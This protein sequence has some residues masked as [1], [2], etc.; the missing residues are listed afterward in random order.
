L[1]QNKNSIVSKSQ[2]L[3]IWLNNSKY[4]SEYLYGSYSRTKKSVKSAGDCPR[5]MQNA[6]V[7]G[8]CERKKV[9]LFAAC[10]L[11]ANIC[12]YRAH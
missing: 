8:R 2:K 6:P 11:K 7:V 10:Q 12:R 1:G 3:K 4:H 5:L 9:R